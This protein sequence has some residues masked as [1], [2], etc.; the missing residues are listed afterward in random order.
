MNKKIFL[1]VLNNLRLQLLIYQELHLIV[2]Q[3]QK[4]LIKK[5]NNKIK[6]NLKFLKKKN[7]I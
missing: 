7:K 5:N 4:N 3:N 6:L 1:R 2:Y